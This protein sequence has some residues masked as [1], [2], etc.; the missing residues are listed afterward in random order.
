VLIHV[1]DEQ[2]GGVFESQAIHVHLTQARQV[3]DE[4]VS[5]VPGSLLHNTAEPRVIRMRD[6]PLM[7]I[8]PG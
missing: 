4:L 3:L 5:G 2:K 6:V 8:E 7:R 1:L